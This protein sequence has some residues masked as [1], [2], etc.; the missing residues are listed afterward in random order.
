MDK[1]KKS[2]RSDKDPGLERSNTLRSAKRGKSS[3]KVASRD[4]VS[5][6]NITR[7]SSSK[8]GFEKV[9]QIDDNNNIKLDKTQQFLSLPTKL[10]TVNLGTA[11]P[12]ERIGVNQPSF[13]DQLTEKVE[14]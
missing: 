6:G 12:L 3:F 11:V 14:Q 9:E 8:N 4:N 13:L 10:N 7:R 1:I 5:K 2:M